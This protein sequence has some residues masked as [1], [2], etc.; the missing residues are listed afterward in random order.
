MRPHQN[1]DLEACVCVDVGHHWR[2]MEFT[3]R[4]QLRGSAHRLM[5][6]MACSSST[7]VA[8]NW[9]GRPIQG[10]RSYEYDE[11]F[12]TNARLLGD[13]PWERRANYRKELMAR[14][15]AARQART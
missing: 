8:L 12:I 15:K 14:D 9:E 10:T 13:T 6:C 11:V 3:A 4:P 7:T 5:L 1:V 2:H